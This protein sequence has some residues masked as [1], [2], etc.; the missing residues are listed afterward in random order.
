LD[1][2]GK[3]IQTAKKAHEEGSAFGSVAGSRQAKLYGGIKKKVRQCRIGVR[4]AQK[5]PKWLGLRREKM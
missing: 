4:I 3:Q 2:K 1:Q 5:K